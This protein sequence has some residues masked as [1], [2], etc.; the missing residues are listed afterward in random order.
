M[1]AATIRQQIE[2]SMPGDS[3]ATGGETINAS[4]TTNDQGQNL[5]AQADKVPG[6][7][8]LGQKLPWTF[9]ILAILTAALIIFLNDSHRRGV[10]SLSISLLI[11][12]A[13]LLVFTIIA[14]LI[15]QQVG[16]SIGS[17]NNEAGN[18]ALAI[19]R[20]SISQVNVPLKIFAAAYLLIGII[21][22]VVPRLI[23]PRA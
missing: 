11:T 10:K 7:F 21:G 12:G 14:S 8:Q 13:L 1:N 22:L 19:A 5:F 23:K 6:M 2:A 3:M 4:D 20:T 15:F 9:G 17:I 18:T 16:A